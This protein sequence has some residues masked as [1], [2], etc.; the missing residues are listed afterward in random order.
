VAGAGDAELRALARFGESFGVAFQHADD[1][2]DA[3]HPEHAAAARTR[4][5]ALIADAVTSVAPLA[6]RGARLAQFARRLLPQP[7]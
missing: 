6:G 3:D 7:G 4:L 1:L 2:D 5:E